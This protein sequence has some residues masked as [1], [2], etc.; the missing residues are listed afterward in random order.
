MWDEEKRL[1]FQRKFDCVEVQSLKN[2]LDNLK[3]SIS[4][5][6]IDTFCQ[7]LNSVILEAGKRVGAVKEREINP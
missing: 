1:N 7:S 2:E 4:Q 3:E 6:A 5:D